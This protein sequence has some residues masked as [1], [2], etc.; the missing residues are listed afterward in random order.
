ME[1]GRW[2][3][4]GWVEEEVALAVAVGVDVAAAVVVVLLEGLLEF[5][6]VLQQGLQRIEGSRVFSPCGFEMDGL[7][8]FRV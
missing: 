7:G 5:L 3:V 4:E 2:K 6:R 8:P 1:G